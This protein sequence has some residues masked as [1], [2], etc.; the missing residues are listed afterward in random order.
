MRI[1]VFGFTELFNDGPINFQI[2]MYTR[3]HHIFLLKFQ[4]HLNEQIHDSFPKNHSLQNT[5]EQQHAKRPIL[6]Q[7]TYQLFNF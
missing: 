5:T 6:Y 1:V 3:L 7:F 4:F 2:S